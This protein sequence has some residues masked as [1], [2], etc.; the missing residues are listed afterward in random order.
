MPPPSETGRSS[1]WKPPANAFVDAEPELSRPAGVAAFTSGVTRGRFAPTTLPELD[2]ELPEPVPMLPELDPALPE[3]E[4]ELDVMLP[5]LEPD[6]L[7]PGAA[8][9]GPLL[10]EQPPPMHATT[11]TTPSEPAPAIVR[12][13]QESTALRRSQ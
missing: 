6:G 8:P 2:P 11:T 13:I 4:P 3:L 5:E 1:T 10:D 9:L 12:I 7:M